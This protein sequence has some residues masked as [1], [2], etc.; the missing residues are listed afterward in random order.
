MSARPTAA[1]YAVPS[2]PAAGAVDAFVRG[3]RAP[4]APPAPATPPS[5][6]ERVTRSARLSVDVPAAVLRRLKIR[7]IEQR[8]TVREY[9]LALLARDGL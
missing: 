2:R 4:E 5:D 1:A 9:V 7:A 6:D 8:T 3:E